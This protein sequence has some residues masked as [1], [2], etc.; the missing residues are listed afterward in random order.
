[1]NHTLRIA[2]GALITA[3]SILQYVK[4]VR[5]LVTPAAVVVAVY[6]KPVYWVLHVMSLSQVY[7][8]TYSCTSERY[9]PLS[10]TKGLILKVCK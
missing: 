2:K 8:N 3:N 7:T 5:F 9:M 6:W 10:V 4:L 1:M